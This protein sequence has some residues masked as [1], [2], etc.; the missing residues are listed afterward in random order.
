MNPVWVAFACGLVLGTTTGI[1][2]AALCVAARRADEAMVLAAY[3]RAVARRQAVERYV[4][5][6]ALERA[7]PEV[8][9]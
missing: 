2:L 8:R 9:N 5:A 4:G 6:K 1:F 3:E 7:H